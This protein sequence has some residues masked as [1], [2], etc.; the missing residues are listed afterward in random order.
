M[1]A[2]RGGGTVILPQS[3]PA[4]ALVRTRRIASDVAGK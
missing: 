4:A 1:A 2:A 3:V